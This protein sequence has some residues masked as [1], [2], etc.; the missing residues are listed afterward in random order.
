MPD[1]PEHGSDPRALAA[2][3]LARAQSPLRELPPRLVLVDV[4]GQRVL[5]IVRGRP[6]QVGERTR[7]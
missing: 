7:V 6:R 4:A 3:A 2:A 5:A 1:L